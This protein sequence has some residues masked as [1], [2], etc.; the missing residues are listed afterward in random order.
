MGISRWRAIPIGILL[1]MVLSGPQIG[2]DEPTA[3]TGPNQQPPAATSHRTYQPP[4]RTTVPVDRERFGEGWKQSVPLEGTGDVLELWVKDGW[5]LVRRLDDEHAVDWQ[6]LLTKIAAG[7]TPSI[8][9]IHSSAGKG[10]GFEVSYA[11]G[12]YFIRDEHGVLRS[13]RQPADADQGPL[14][15]ELFGPLARDRGKAQCLAANLVVLHWRENGWHIATSARNAERAQTLVRLCQHDAEALEWGFRSSAVLSHFFV[16]DNWVID[17]GAML[18]A[19]RVLL[20]NYREA[21]REL[22]EHNAV[23]QGPPPPLDIATWLNTKEPLSLDKL[24]GRVVLLDFWGTWCGPCVRKLPDVQRF[25]DRY[26]GRGLVVIGVHSRTEGDTCREF[27]EMHRLTIPIAIDSGKTAKD[28]CVT[29]WPSMFLID[30]LG[31]FVQA[32]EDELPEDEIVQ[33]LLKD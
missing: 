29:E 4:T 5:L 33:S 2:A 21:R 23:K 20:A 22:Q 13:L 15:R 19:D 24:R 26:A 18:L 6:I 9:T 17:D 14:C 12:R 1:S 28:Y 11:D 8:A 3:D 31:R 16:D 32:F 7:Q 30:K 25:A 27:V 10:L